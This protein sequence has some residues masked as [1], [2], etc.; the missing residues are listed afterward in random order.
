MSPSKKKTREREYIDTERN[1]ADEEI[2]AVNQENCAKIDVKHLSD[3]FARLKKQMK[4]MERQLRP[5]ATETGKFEPGSVTDA[6]ISS[7]LSNAHAN[8]LL[9]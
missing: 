8:K 5:V 1:L 3:D 6:N 7:D 4:E 9:S 2:G